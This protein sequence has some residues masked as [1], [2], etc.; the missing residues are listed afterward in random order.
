MAALSS[1]T[2][3]VTPSK[4]R[5]V[6]HRVFDIEGTLAIHRRNTSIED[7]V[8]P[9]RQIFL[10]WLKIKTYIPS[11]NQRLSQVAHHHTTTAY[12]KTLE[13]LQAW[14]GRHWGGKLHFASRAFRAIKDAHYQNVELVYQALDLLANEYRSMRLNP[15][16]EARNIYERKRLSLGLENQP[17]FASEALANE[18]GDMYFIDWQGR[19]CLLSDHLKK[20]NSHNHQYCLRIYYFWCD[21]TEQVII[22]WL[23]SHLRNRQT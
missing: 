13:D 23:P 8:V 21:E 4:P 17:T 7:I 18:Q 20:G 15:G 19:R 2:H 10:D 16:I 12:P 9:T 14:A 6:I 22:G 11:E 1:V 3:F 5:P